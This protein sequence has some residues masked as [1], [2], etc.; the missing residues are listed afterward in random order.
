MET[1]FKSKLAGSSYATEN[2]KKAKGPFLASTAFY[3]KAL[4]HVWRASRKAKKGTLCP[5]TLSFHSRGVLSAVESSGG[6]IELEG[7]ENLDA[8]DGP[9]ILAANHMSSL[10]TFSLPSIVQP[11][12]KLT[13]V[14]KQSLLEY[15]V[16]GRVLNAMDPIAVSRNNPREDLKAV[17]NGGKESI[18]K[19]WSICVFPQTTRTTVFERAKFNTLAV[20]LAARSKIPLIPLALKTDF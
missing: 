17:L 16:F 10:E 11:R 8:V 14:L 5:E 19:G 9:F 18:A 4:S 6:R 1:D 20:K 3:S 15:P 12:N 2:P 7:L 13:F